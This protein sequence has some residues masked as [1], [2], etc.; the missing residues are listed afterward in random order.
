[1][2]HRRYPR[3]R[4][5]DTAIVRAIERKTVVTIPDVLADP[6]YDVANAAK[7]FR[8]ALGVP[9]LRD[10][11]PIDAIGIGRAEIGRLQRKG[12]CAPSDLR[13][14]GGDRDRERASIHGSGAT[15]PAAD[16]VGERAQ[17]AG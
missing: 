4:G 16:A 2:M 17:G 7:E 3:K 12:D 13:R 8:S 6:E 15:D 5:R 14:P 9:L 10:G 1:T 11:E